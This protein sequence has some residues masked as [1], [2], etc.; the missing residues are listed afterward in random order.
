MKMKPLLRLM[1]LCILASTV[2]PAHS[3]VK[4]GLLW[5]IS[6]NGL[7]KPSY[8]YGTIHLTDKRVFNFGDS[9]YAALESSA[10][11]AMELDPDSMMVYYINDE[12]KDKFSPLVKDIVDPKIFSAAKKKL[13]QAFHKKA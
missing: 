7:S 8:L 10:G 1:M 6:G 4:K 13:E 9:L 5:R 2:V 11:Y 12:S 3:Q